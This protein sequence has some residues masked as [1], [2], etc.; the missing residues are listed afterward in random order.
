MVGFGQR[1]N[2]Q[3]GC[4]DKRSLPI[5][6]IRKYPEL[7]RQT[8]TDKKKTMPLVAVAITGCIQKTGLR[9]NNSLTLPK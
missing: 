5:M 8:V 7:H 2:T 1:R 3:N 4:V 6:Q 9:A